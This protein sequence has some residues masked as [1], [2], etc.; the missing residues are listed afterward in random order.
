[1]VTRLTVGRAWFFY[2]S[3]FVFNVI[4]I[5]FINITAIIFT[6]IAYGVKTPIHS[7]N[8]TGLSDRTELNEQT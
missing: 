3:Y 1:L 8:R 5:S 4:A 7:T 2:A 6:Y